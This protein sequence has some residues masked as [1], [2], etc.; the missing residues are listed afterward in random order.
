[1]HFFFGTQT[2]HFPSF[3]STL[4]SLKFFG[5]VFLFGSVSVY[6]FLFF[7]HHSITLSMVVFYRIPENPGS[8]GS[9]SFF[10]YL[11]HIMCVFHLLVSFLFSKYL[12]IRSSQNFCFLISY[13]RE[14]LL[15]VFISS[16]IFFECRI[17]Q[18]RSK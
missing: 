3:S 7:K 11:V 12:V 18:K 14:H 9:S 1:M 13:G 4:A 6:D 8:R 15:F 2:C 17:L 10:L 16:I 5:V